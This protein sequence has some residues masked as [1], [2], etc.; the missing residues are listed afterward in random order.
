MGTDRM[1]TT[2]IGNRIELSRDQWDG[3]KAYI[4][5]Y[6]G[7]LEAVQKYTWTYSGGEHPYLRSSKLKTSL[8]KF[9]LAF[10][11]GAG[12]LEKMLL[13]DNIIEHLD[14]NGLNCSYDNLHILSSDRNKGKA[15]LI[16]KE[17]DK[18]RL[19]VHQIAHRQLR[20]YCLPL[21]PSLPGKSESHLPVRSG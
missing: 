16:D 17:A 9:V 3:H 2:V 11:Y 12:N 10:L 6:P 19:C 8:H 20:Q 18:F 4:S 7:L 5:D 15:F 21:H 1:K 14:N 13:P